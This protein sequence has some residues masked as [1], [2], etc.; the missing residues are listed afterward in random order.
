MVG[1]A[2]R[3]TGTKPYFILSLRKHWGLP[4]ACYRKPDRLALAG[5]LT[6]QTLV[7]GAYEAGDKPWPGI[8]TASHWS[9]EAVPI[10]I[11]LIPSTGIVNEGK[12][13]TGP[14]PLWGEFQPG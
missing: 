10:V 11:D 6:R 2:R 14:S 13:A 4:A 5:H 7:F 3:R 8:P 12:Q 1:I 9:S